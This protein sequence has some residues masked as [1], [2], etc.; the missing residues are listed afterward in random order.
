MVLIAIMI[1]HFSCIP[2]IAFSEVSAYLM[3]CFKL[4]ILFMYFA[5]SECAITRE[6]ITFKFIL[7]V[8]NN[9]PI[10]GNNLGRRMLVK[11]LMY[12]TAVT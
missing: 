5:N 10:Y 2:I 8:D 12:F 3:H 1:R 9:F 11:R 6:S 4:F 7:F